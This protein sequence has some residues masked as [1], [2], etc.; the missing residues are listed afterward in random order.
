MSLFTAD[1]EIV[2]LARRLFLVDIF[3]HL[4]RSFNHSFN[5]GLRS[6]VYVFWPMV[7]AVC[8]IWVCNVGL[9]LRV[10]QRLRA[11]RRRVMARADDR[12]VGARPFDDDVMAAGR[13]WKAG[14][15][16]KQAVQDEAKARLRALQNFLYHTTPQAGFV[17]PGEL[18]FVQNAHFNI[19][20]LLYDEYRK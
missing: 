10:F 20:S 11:W 9:W 7:I 6:W 3:I 18:F 5:Y 15:V 1:P 17:P 19:K 14:L 16:E 8:S 4:G 2:A 13:K 12:R